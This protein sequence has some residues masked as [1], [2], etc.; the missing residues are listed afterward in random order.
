MNTSTPVTLPID[1]IR[2]YW[3][4]PRKISDA[5]VDAVADSIT[6]YGYQSPII[7]DPQHVVIVGHTRLR[8]LRKLGWTQVPVLVADL[9]PA[10]VREYRV[11]D[12]RTSEFTRWDD[13]A[14]LLELREFSEDVLASYFPTVDLAT[15]FAAGFDPVTA[16]D[17]EQATARVT[18]SQVT[19]ITEPAK[20]GAKPAETPGG[21]PA[22]E[23]TTILALT[24]PHCF[25]TIEVDPGGL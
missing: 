3:R 19:R 7:V 6:R 23:T 22:A 15:E 9:P 11:M 5:A 10:K 25:Q 20:P 21:A 24:C 12:N 2:P 16:A 14:L 1:D 18:S 8:A 17:V 13:D 4:N